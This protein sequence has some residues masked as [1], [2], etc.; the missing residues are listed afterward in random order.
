MSIRPRNSENLATGIY[1]VK[2]DLWPDTMKDTI[3]LQRNHTICKLIQLFKSKETTQCTWE[4]KAHLL[5]YQTYG[6]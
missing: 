2:N 1:R 6:N 4:Q 3:F 5:L